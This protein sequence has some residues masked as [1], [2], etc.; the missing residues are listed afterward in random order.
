MVY[1]W[2]IL[3]IG[4]LYATYDLLREPKTTID[5]LS[6]ANL[7]QMGAFAGCYRTSSHPPRISFVVW[8]GGCGRS[9]KMENVILLSGIVG[10]EHAIYICICKYAHLYIIYIYI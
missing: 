9:L 8:G 5:S 2:Y 7:F 6:C 3:P 10:G 1:K 4:G